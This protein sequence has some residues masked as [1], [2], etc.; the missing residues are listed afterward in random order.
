MDHNDRPTWIQA[1]HTGLYDDDSG[2]VAAVVA[3]NDFWACFRQV[4]FFA[5]SASGLE[6][7]WRS[8]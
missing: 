4:R 3:S 6:A 1:I 7:K 2:A 5:L 8:P